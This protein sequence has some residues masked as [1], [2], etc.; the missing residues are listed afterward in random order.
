[1]NSRTRFLITALTLAAALSVAAA[2][3]AAAQVGRISG[4]VT[5]ETGEPIKGATVRSASQQNP[6]RKLVATTD[7]NG[8]FVFIVERSGQWDFVVEAPGFAPVTGSSR[9]RLAPSQPPI[10]VT[11]ERREAPEMAGTLAGVN[12]RLISTQLTAADGLYDAGRYDEAIAA[13]R[14]IQSQ[15]PALTV[16][17]LQ[18]G[19]AYLQKKDYDSA[20]TEYQAVLKSD[21]ANGSAC[22]NL[23]DVRAARGALSEATDW[24]ER[25]A[26]SDPLWTKPLMKLAAIARDA[27]NRE[28]AIGYLKKVVAIDPGSAEAAQASSLLGQLGRV[29]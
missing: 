15:T 1:M 26:R 21:P 2:G 10:E 13:Y 7:E 28:V 16:V 8:R 14:K 4:T 9:V 17:G 5:D 3:P 18:L 19:N 22:Y 6:G 20:E 27:G 11:L 23:G 24:Y 12:P 25:A 29:N